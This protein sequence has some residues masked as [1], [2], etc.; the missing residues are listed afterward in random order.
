MRKT[1]VAWTSLALGMTGVVFC[2]CEM[3]ESFLLTGDVSILAPRDGGCW[4]GR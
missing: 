1:A 3:P 4:Y 2:G